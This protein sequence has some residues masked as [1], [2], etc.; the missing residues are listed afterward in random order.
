MVVGLW[1]GVADEILLDGGDG[2]RKLDVEFDDEVAPHGR[3]LR[4]R[5]AHVRQSERKDTVI[6][7]FSGLP[8][9]LKFF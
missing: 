9:N 5:Q 3:V 1:Q 8:S 6:I 7:D 2:R 4:I